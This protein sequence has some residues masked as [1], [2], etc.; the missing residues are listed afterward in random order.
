MARKHSPPAAWPIALTVVLLWLWAGC[1]LDMHDQPK[2]KSYKAS[3]FYDDGRASRQPPRGT[4]PF[5]G[6]QQDQHFFT[7]MINGKPA[8][9]FP[10]PVTRQLLE[11]GRERFNIYCAPCHDRTGTGQGMIVQRGMKLPPSYHI[12]RLREAPPGY[13]F[14]V[15]TRGFGA[16]YSY[17]SR[18]S[19]HDRW[20]IVAYIRALQLSQHATI[21][22]I[23]QEEMS[24]LEDEN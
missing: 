10:F 16:M 20:A 9:E 22:D 12:T 18:I 17:A 6:A 19:P 15:M 1:R 4:V 8:A 21:G 14:D 11:R 2:Y 24:R 23:P 13:F 7:G 5:G 3:E